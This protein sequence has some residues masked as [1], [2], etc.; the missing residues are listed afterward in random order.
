MFSFFYNRLYK[1]LLIGL[2]VLTTLSTFPYKKIP[3]PMLIEFNETIKID[4][5]ISNLTNACFVKESIGGS[6]FAGYASIFAIKD[7]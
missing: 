2:V 5:R 1:K 4:E 6:H 7:Y 3:Y